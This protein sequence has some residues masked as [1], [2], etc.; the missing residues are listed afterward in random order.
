MCY[1][2]DFPG[3]AELGTLY[4][5][6]FDGEDWLANLFEHRRGRIMKPF[7]RAAFATL[8]MSFAGAA[9]AELTGNIGFMSEYIFRG[10]PQA[11]SVANG[12][13]DYEQGGFYIGTWAADVGMGAE[14]DGYLGY[15]MSFGDFEV[16]LGATRYYYTDDFDETYEEIN[17]H[18]GYKFVSFEYTMGEYD[19]ESTEDYTFFATRLEHKGLYGEYGR[20]GDDFDGD[21]FQ[22]GYDTTLHGIDLGIALISSDDE[23]SGDDDNT[24]L[25]VTVSKT[26]SILDQ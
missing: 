8:V 20:F 10:V 5:S 22:V 11:D 6:D 23:L 3:L 18:A 2:V 21:Y 12:G 26:F 7:T 14:V 13:L 1:R 9:Q 15:N 17:V 4:A 19:V 25:I 16:G 24:H